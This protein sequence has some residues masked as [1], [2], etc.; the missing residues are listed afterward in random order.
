MQSWTAF[1]APVELP[2]GRILVSSVPVVERVDDDGR[3][4]RVLPADATAW[5]H[6]EP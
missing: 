6:V 3:R 1:G 2:P 5:V 4:V